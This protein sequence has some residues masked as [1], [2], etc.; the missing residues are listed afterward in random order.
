MILLGFPGD[1]KSLLF[2]RV[3]CLKNMILEVCKCNKTDGITLIMVPVIIGSSIHVYTIKKC[4]VQLFDTRHNQVMEN[5]NSEFS[6]HVL[7]LAGKKCV[8]F[9]LHGISKLGW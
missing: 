4:L 8:C 6:T 1:M 7:D 9:R 5:L 3:A 2:F